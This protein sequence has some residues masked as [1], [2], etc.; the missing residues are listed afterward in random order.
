MLH[1]KG[2]LKLQ[3][4]ICL[5]SADPKIGKLLEYQGVEVMCSQISSEVK[6]GVGRISV[7]MIQCEKG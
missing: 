6:E 3:T 7:K 1:G 4:E 2:E 5:Q